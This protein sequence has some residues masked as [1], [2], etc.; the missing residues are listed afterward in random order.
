[1]AKLTQKEIKAH[2]RAESLHRSDRVLNLD[3]IADILSDW[4]EGAT[5][6]NAA[7][8][9]FFTPFELAMNFALE[10]PSGGRILDICSGIGMLSAAAA[11]YHASNPGDF[12]F[13]L[14]ELDE[15]YCEVDRR[16]DERR[17]GKECV[18]TCRCR[19]ERVQLTKKK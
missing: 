12:E 11:I 15:T 18:S 8:S 1:M 16:S 2:A 17:V 6:S 4:H 14:V 19:W 10:V 7:T 13:T 5:H 9:A 3:D